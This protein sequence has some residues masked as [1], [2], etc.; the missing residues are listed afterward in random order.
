MNVLSLFGELHTECFRL[1]TIPEWVKTKGFSDT[2]L[3]K[4]AGNGWTVKVIK[5][6]LSFY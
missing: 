5:H 3:Y 6:I 2:A 4:M 1:Q